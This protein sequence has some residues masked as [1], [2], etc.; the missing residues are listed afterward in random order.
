MNE[1]KK[2]EWS[3][4]GK[5]LF[6]ALVTA[7]ICGCAEKK[8]TLYLYTWSDYIAPEVIADFEKA[9]G[10]HVCIDTFTSNEALY[11]KLRTGGGAY[12]LVFPSTFFIPMLRDTKLIQPFDLNLL[13]RVRE[14]FDPDFKDKI[15]DP[16]FTFSVPYTLFYTGLA[17]NARKVTAAPLSWEAYMESPF[18]TR[19]TLLG[20]MRMTI[21]AALKVLGYSLNSTRREEIEA[22][23]QKVIGWKEKIAR[24][25][26]DGYKIGL[27]TGEFLLCMAYNGDIAQVQEELPHIRFSYPKEG[28][29]CSSDEICLPLAARHVELA[30][31]FVDFLYDPDTAARNMAFNGFCMPVRGA[32]GRLDPD[33]RRKRVRFPDREELSRAELLRP[34][35]SALPLYIKAW[36]LIKAAE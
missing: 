13:P 32:V 2:R 34:V 25:D 30:H 11:A 23:T 20:D 24:F 7:M 5:G 4:R 29:P 33:L 17:Y 31:R 18:K 19:S 15:F 10:C 12:D 22:A 36:D 26:T 6:F 27:A 1:G 21:G 3:K 35:G 9:N 28:Y 8:P 16:T 14:N